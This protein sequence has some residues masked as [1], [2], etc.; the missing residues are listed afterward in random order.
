MLILITGATGYIGSR[1]TCLALKRGHDVTILSRQRPPSVAAS[2]IAFDLL[3]DNPIELP[4]GMD[5]V[6]HLATTFAAMPSSTGEMEIVATHELIKAAQNTGAK[7][8]FVSSQT[9]RADAPTAYGR[10]K[11]RIEQ[12]VRAAEGWVVRP[13]QV[14]GGSLRGLFGLL[15]RTVKNLPILPAFMPAPLIQPV[16][17]EDLAEGLLRIA[18][19][20]DIPPNI[21]CIAASE[22][23]SFTKFL[24]EISRTRLRRWRG[25]VPVPVAA[26]NTLAFILGES[27]RTRL[28]LERLQSLF[29]LPLMKTQSDL[30][31]LG[32]TLRPLRSGMHR[33][34]ND[35][36][37]RLLREGR[38]FLTYILK[39]HPNSVLLRRYARATEQLRDGQTLVLPSLFLN[40]PVFLSL[41]D[42]L[43]WG[44]PATWEEFSWRLDVATIL[45]EATPLGAHRFLG[46][47]NEQGAL[48]HLLLMTK[49]VA[50]EAFWR[51]LRI[52]F[53][54]FVR[55]TLGRARR[56]S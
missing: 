20:H 22:P 53:F 2:W 4:A 24:N 41:F 5:A 35:R 32:L 42:R 46:L 15:V 49:A 17:V 14:Y 3:S 1:L 8:I 7:F 43:T 11:W 12:M 23:V 28:G 26:V 54:P 16:H 45:A 29:N 50:N 34:G 10:T 18:E 52:F 44:D 55:F 30:D 47:E 9:A 51:A 48:S 21:Y 36:R 13:G 56:I 38:A 19:R 6:I 39:E 27:L 31:K 37:R 25:F 33:S 40:Y